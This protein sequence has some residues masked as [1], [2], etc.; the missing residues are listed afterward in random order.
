MKGFLWEIESQV[1][2]GE[3]RQHTIK[4]QRVL[5]GSRYRARGGFRY[6]AL[7]GGEFRDLLGGEDGIVFEAGMEERWAWE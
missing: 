4:L 2:A 3:T 6:R 1:K 7:C 5:V